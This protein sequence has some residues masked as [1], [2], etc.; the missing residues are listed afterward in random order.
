MPTLTLALFL[1]VS[2]TAT[3]PVIAANCSPGAKAQADAALK[4]IA[5]DEARRDKLI[6]THAPF[7][8]HRTTGDT[9]GEQVLVQGQDHF[10]LRSGPV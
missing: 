3:S 8:L 1:L 9:S 5:A 2:T 6:A 10:T 7:G 4:A